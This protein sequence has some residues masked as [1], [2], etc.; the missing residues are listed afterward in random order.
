MTEQFKP[1]YH[2]SNIPKGEVGEISKIE[3]EVREL[4]DAHDQHA[5]V[6]ELVELSDLVGAITMY[7]ER[8]HPSVT[9]EDLRTMAAITRRAFENG[10]RS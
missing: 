3:E 7:L 9:L 2:L 6:M 8:H 1:G 10:H 5:A 4:R